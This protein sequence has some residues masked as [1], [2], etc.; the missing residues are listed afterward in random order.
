MNKVLLQTCQ[1]FSHIWQKITNIW[2]L[3]LFWPAISFF[4]SCMLSHP[5]LE[6][7][8]FCKLF[9]SALFNE[10][11]EWFKD[12]TQT[13]QSK[14]K[15]TQKDPQPTSQVLSMV[16]DPF[17]PNACPSPPLS[18]VLSNWISKVSVDDLTHMLLLHSG[19]VFSILVR[20][21]SHTLSDWTVIAETSMSLTLN[22]LIN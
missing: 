17:F 6:P 19:Y 2:K 5:I 18:R 1:W 14:K 11:V 16:D 8:S 7:F 13:V 12:M 22:N 4:L 21:F 20:C 3:F 15:Q 10:G 9:L